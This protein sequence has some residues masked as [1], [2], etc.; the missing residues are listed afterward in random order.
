MALVELVLPVKPRS[1]PLYP[2]NDAEIE[3][4]NPDG[5]STGGSYAVGDADVGKGPQHKEGVQLYDVSSIPAGATIVR[6]KFELIAAS[7]RDTDF[8]FKVD[9]IAEV[10]ELNSIAPSPRT[11]TVDARYCVA[12]REGATELSASNLLVDN[13]R[14]TYHLDGRSD[15]EPRFEQAL[16]IDTAGT[17]DTIVWR[18]YSL[19]LLGTG[20]FYSR[21]W[22]ST[23]VAGNYVRDR[24]IGDGA[25]NPIDFS[26]ID[27]A[28]ANVTMTTSK[29]PSGAPV[30]EVG[31]VVIAE[32][33]F[34]PTGGAQ[35]DARIFIT[36]NTNPSLIPALGSI[37]NMAQTGDPALEGFTFMTNFLG[38]TQIMEAANT[39]TTLNMPQ[40]LDA[41]FI[42]TL[43]IVGD[44]AYSPDITLAGF[45]D[46]IAE[47]IADQSSGNIAL[48][49]FAP[50]TGADNDIR[51]YRSANG[52]EDTRPGIK[53]VILVIEYE[54]PEGFD[55][56]SHL[57]TEIRPGVNHLGTGVDPAVSNLGA[58][59]G[60]AVTQRGAILRPSVAHRGALARPSTQHRGT[61]AEPA[62]EILG[63]RAAPSV[64]IVCADV[65]L[66]VRTLGATVNSSVNNQGADS[67]PAVSH[68]GMRVF[69]AV[70]ARV[71]IGET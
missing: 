3:D 34:V 57:G 21:I 4:I 7:D 47:A 31:D 50:V 5:I 65:S 10:S 35:A 28:A 41:W 42:D 16:T 53:G 19:F 70:S 54:E 64:N 68:Y 66:A 25:Y 13:F 56:V 37:D 51:Q 26:V 71:T 6:A 67:S 29:F 9:C 20:T 18:I 49:F 30:V 1:N 52:I 36:C 39:G 17:L 43:L 48:R 24:L 32:I 44:A 14:A 2:A 22:S 46:L 59:V 11:I 62:V 38:G 33:T 58:H 27:V 60:G 69:P 15:H 61:G 40:P 23:G 63:L 12:V 8:N 45:G 55:A